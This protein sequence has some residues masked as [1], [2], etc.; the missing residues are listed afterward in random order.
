MLSRDL[1]HAFFI[2]E[3]ET[4][5][6]TI[7]D[8][9]NQCCRGGTALVHARIKFNTKAGGDSDNFGEELPLGSDLD[10][11]AFSL[12]IV[13]TKALLFMHWAEVRAKTWIVRVVDKANDGLNSRKYGSD[14]GVK[15]DVAYHKNLFE[16]YDFNCLSPSS[17]RHRDC[18][19][20]GRGAEEV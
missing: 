7:E 17:K 15:V 9:D 11:I 20:M 1:C 4:S 19:G 10:S 6:G 16:S 13:P 8:V 18:V 3:A 14:G 5:E 12:A 2:I